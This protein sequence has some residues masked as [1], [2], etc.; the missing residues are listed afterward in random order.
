MSFN[1]KAI[2]IICAVVAVALLCPIA[3]EIIY[4][5]M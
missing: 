4:M 1:K 5:F 3:I 2:R